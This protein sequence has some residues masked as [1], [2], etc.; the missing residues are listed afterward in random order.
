MPPTVSVIL[1]VYNAARFL[2]PC[3]KS[4]LQQSFTDLELII[5][6][7]GSTDHSVDIINSFHDPRI[8]LINN[9][10]N[11]GL[12]YSLNKAVELSNGRYIARMD[13]DDICLPQRIEKQVQLLNSKQN[14]SV[15]ACP[16][17]FINEKD[18]DIAMRWR[19]DEVNISSAD[20]RREMASGN[21]IAHPS[22]MARAEVLKSHPYP[23][24]QQHTEDYA[25]WLQLIT[26]GY[27]FEKVP[28]K[29]LRYRVH[30][31]SVTH[32]FHRKKNV[33]LINAN[34]KFKFLRARLSKFRF[35]GFD[36]LVSMMMVRDLMG[37]LVKSTKRK[38]SN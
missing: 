35:N 5:I 25:L 4:V 22:I 29:L 36:L 27:E 16:V 17:Q 34:T 14:I 1:P 19:E 21:C 2:K 6:N 23:M 28:E 13:A 33:Y 10:G 38:F 9:D 8:R 12:I 37:A 24:N 31:S 32:Q 18:E 20:I 15:T 3:I 30:Q 26:E 7:D 11:K